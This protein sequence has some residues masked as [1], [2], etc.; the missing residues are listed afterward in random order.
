M[1]AGGGFRAISEPLP[2]LWRANGGPGAASKDLSVP[3]CVIVEFDDVR[4]T[5]VAGQ[6][7]T[8]FPG[9]PEKAKWV[10]IFKQDV[11]SSMD[12]RVRREQFPLVL[13]CIF[14]MHAVL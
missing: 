7:R 2:S 4:M 11:S 14:L 3:E 5:D 9:E 8:Y 12:E 6:T 1:C 13:A 10:P